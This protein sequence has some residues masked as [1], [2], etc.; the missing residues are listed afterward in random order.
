MKLISNMEDKMSGFV[1]Q[2]V[3]AVAVVA[4]AI[5]AASFSAQPVKAAD[6]LLTAVAVG[7]TV[8][9]VNAHY[10]SKRACTCYKSCRTSYRS[11][12]PRKHAHYRLP[13]ACRVSGHGGRAYIVNC[14]HRHGYR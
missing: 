14:L 3:R 2:A 10:R 1:T 13:A 9:G 8:L 11:Y 5:G 4:L 7:A 12:H 6:P